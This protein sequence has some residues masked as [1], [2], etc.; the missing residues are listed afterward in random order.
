MFPSLNPRLQ[1]HTIVVLILYNAMYN[2][3]LRP[4]FPTNGAL[5]LRT[6]VRSENVLPPKFSVVLVVGMEPRIDL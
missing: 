5:E 1:H 3:L 6:V 4:G 2:V